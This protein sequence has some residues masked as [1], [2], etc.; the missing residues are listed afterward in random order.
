MWSPAVNTGEE[1]RLPFVGRPHLPGVVLHPLL[2]AAH[3]APVHL[4]KVTGQHQRAAAAGTPERRLTTGPP[5]SG[6]ASPSKAA[7]LSAG[8]RTTVE[9]VCWPW[10]SAHKHTESSENLTLRSGG[11]EGPGTRVRLPA[12]GMEKQ[13]RGQRTESCSPGT[14]RMLPHS[15][16]K[17]RSEEKHDMTARNQRAAEKKRGVC[18]KPAHK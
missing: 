18:S 4:H 6:A 13:Q 10:N 8:F 5:G 11:S 2:A 15:G 1:D 17:F 14:G 16:Q 12:A 7:G 3:A 9:R